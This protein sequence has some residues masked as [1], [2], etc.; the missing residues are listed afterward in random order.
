MERERRAKGVPTVVGAKALVH[1]GEAANTTP[2]AN[3]E[4]FMVD[5]I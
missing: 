2:R 5:F 4:S 3:V 1:D